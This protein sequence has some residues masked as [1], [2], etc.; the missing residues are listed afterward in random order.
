M[1]TKKGLIHLYEGDGKGKTTAALGLCIR[2]A[3]NGGTVV[4]TQFLKGN[5]SGELKILEQI[6]GI[7]LLRC[8]RSFGFTFQMTREEKKEAAAYYSSHLKQV[9]ETAVR[10]KAG[11][12]VLDEI[13][14]AYNHR[15]I[16]QE[17]LLS[18]LKNKPEGMEVVLTGRGPAEELLALAD[19][20]TYME[21][22][23]HPYDKGISAR[24]GIEL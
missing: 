2:F 23:K 1:N 11:L 12:F 19:Y 5:D 17:V 10:K 7:R 20:V 6:E 9:L 24:K 4:F 18:F 21:K 14:S 13:I 3:G 22:R 15:M 16:E 8:E